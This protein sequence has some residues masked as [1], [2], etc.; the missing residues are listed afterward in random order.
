MVE[1]LETSQDK[2][3]MSGEHD[4]LVV[5][6]LT[7]V[8]D[9]SGI[10]GLCHCTTCIELHGVH[11]GKLYCNN[12]VHK[13]SMYVRT[14][15][16]DVERNHVIQQAFVC[17]NINQS[18]EHRLKLSVPGRQFWQSAIWKLV[19]PTLWAVF[20]WVFFFNELFTSSLSLNQECRNVWFLLFL[21]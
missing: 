10:P 12:S 11:K 9:K 2:C 14:Q 1:T 17:E 19:R 6:C 3:V 8:W 13:P 7:K 18:A 15:C 21:C 20:S 5:S 4:A 16:G